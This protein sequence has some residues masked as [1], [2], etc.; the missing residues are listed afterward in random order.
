MTARASSLE[1][2]QGALFPKEVRP[3]E[4]AEFHALGFSK[5]VCGV[6]Y[7]LAAPATDGMPLGGID[8]GCIDL[9][10][11]GLWGYCT[12]FNTLVPRRGPVNL[13]FLGLS[14]GGQTWVLCDYT[15]IKQYEKYGLTKFEPVEN[16][17][18]RLHLDRDHLRSVKGI[19][20][21]GHYPVADLEYET[22][23]PVQVALRAWA[24]FLPG[25]VEKSILPGLVFEVHLRN[26]GEK[27]EQGTLAFSFPGPTRNE[28]GA[29]VF[30]R[31]QISQD[32]SG[33]VVSAPKASYALGAIQEP[34]ARLGGEIGSDALRWSKIAQELP[35]AREDQPGS[36][37][38]IDF[39]LKPGDTRV[40]R[41]VLTWV[42]PQWKGGGHPTS[43]YGNTFT[44]T[45]A[46]KYP[47]PA[48]TAELLAKNHEDLLKRILAWQQTIYTEDKLP[49]WLRESLVNNLNLITETSLWA[50]AEPPIPSWVRPEDGMFGLCE[51]PRDC[52]QIECLPCSFY[53]NQ[54]VVYFFPKL[55]L[56]QLRG[57]KGYL[58]KNG[59]AV[60]KWGGGT[61]LDVNM[62]FCDPL[63]EYQDATNGISLASMVD[64]YGLCWGNKNF[65]RE[66]YDMVKQN[67]IYT[68]NLRPEAE[69]GERVISMPT[70]NRGSEWFEAPEPDWSG[71]AAHLGGLHLAQLRIAERMAKQMGDKPFAK[72]CREWIEAGSRAMESKMWNNSYY[73]NFWEPETGKKSDLVFGYQLD[74][75][76]AAR[77]HGL[78]GVF[79][80]DRVQ[81]TLD[82]IARCNVALSK[83]GAINY[84][85]ADGS[86]TDIKGYGAY[87][88]FPP[89]L[90]MLAMT[91]MY[92]GRR[93]FGLDLARRCWERQICVLRYT[94][95]LPNI[96]RG[97]KD[98]G[99]RAFGHDY[100][101]NMMLWS[102]PAAIAGQDFGGPCKPGGLVDKIL[103]AAR[104]K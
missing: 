89:E 78:P 76:W 44:H 4:W 97:D 29:F 68:V 48:E 1:E 18:T 82:T 49:V 11:S 81:T 8:T 47:N 65:L 26:A 100:Y 72:Q 96:L 53:G 61:E 75:Q 91:Y 104:G 25:D 30:P 87:S 73:L 27:E 10:V 9:E 101:Q 86:A 95:D 85:N 7:D 103:R 38:A 31:Q 102:L 67:A 24:P 77:H 17:P 12:L 60:F 83:I 57:Y 45:Y 69:I 6:I 55:A 92:E 41:F 84:A 66:F 70:G 34:K 16:I 56:S 54:P 88:Y 37:M 5:S 98:T 64:R 13:P 51:S 20:Y 80:P 79:R 33:V 46:K 21:W 22:D 23:A 3:S 28:A 99:E 39:T 94:W 19:R 36:S 14:V 93:E 62:E 63:W 15:K 59:G 43:P 32:F 2:A 71:M 35:E 58:A 40:V 50:A 74:G 90:L 42:S 52:P